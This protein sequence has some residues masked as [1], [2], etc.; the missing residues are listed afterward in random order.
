MKILVADNNKTI[1]RIIKTALEEEGYSVESA[2][3]KEDAI[4]LIKTDSSIGAVLMDTKFETDK[5][6]YETARE[7]KSIRDVHVVMLVNALEK[8]DFELMEKIGISSYLTKPVDS[9]KLLQI[10]S[11][12]E[13]S[14]KDKEKTSEEDSVRVEDVKIESPKKTKQKHKRDDDRKIEVKESS[15][16]A[17]EDRRSVKSE[18]A[19]E[20]SEKQYELGEKQVPESIESADEEKEMISHDWIVEQR[21]RML[22]ELSFVLSSVKSI[23]ENIKSIEAEA[24]NHV[25]ELASLV[26]DLRSKIQNIPDPD[27]IVFRAIQQISTDFQKKALD[28]LTERVYGELREEVRSLVVREVE[29]VKALMKAEVKEDLIS[30]IEEEIFRKALSKV[31]SSLYDKIY[32]SLYQALKDDFD[33]LLEGFQRELKQVKKLIA[34]MKANMTERGERTTEY[35]TEE[36]RVDVGEDEHRKG[37]KEEKDKLEVDEIPADEVIFSSPVSSSSGESERSD[38]ADFVSIDD[39]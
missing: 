6:G 27:T 23:F 33:I 39:I 37:T 16:P 25:K 20:L 13:S 11:E 9:R 8:P 5:D 34:D 32:D 30:N 12:I 14:V 10:I 22:D 3:T 18:S 2:N 15:E 24:Q 38:S 19:Y 28:S 31:K 26:P 29:R 17:K 35:E 7:I 36:A 21:D 4:K 1:T